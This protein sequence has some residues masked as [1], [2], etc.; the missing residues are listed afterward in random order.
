MPYARML[1]GYACRGPWECFHGPCRRAPGGDRV[2]TRRGPWRGLSHP[3]T[4]VSDSAAAE[5]ES[6]SHHRL[7]DRPPWRSRADPSGQRPAEN[8]TGDSP[9]GQP[10]EK[11]EI[12]QDKKA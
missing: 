10:T 8:L 5:T 7:S 6:P 1:G 3:A 12:G 11:A 2:G 9:A 4:A